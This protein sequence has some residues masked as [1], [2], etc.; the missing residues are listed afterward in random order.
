[1]ISSEAGGGLS[2]FL[3][4]IIERQSA[5]VKILCDALER[6]VD[7]VIL[8]D[9]LGRPSFLNNTAKRVVEQNDG[10]SIAGG[11]LVARRAS[12]RR[13]LG[14][15]I[16]E[17]L[18]GK[19]RPSAG[20]ANRVLI[21]RPS[22]AKPYILFLM[23]TRADQRIPDPAR[24]ACIVHIHILAQPRLPSEDALREAFGLTR[25]E[26]QL[27]VELVRSPHLGAAASKSGM[28]AN[29]ARNHLRAIFSKTGANN[30]AEA[31]QLLARVP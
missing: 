24:Y 17:I 14:Q 4:E 28:A 30:Q 25:R 23:A 16:E 18:V 2:T 6:H 31:I 3:L 8:L 27:V 26:A 9:G 22:G 19:A 15:A 21:S 7:G 29:T 11:T 1:M 5:L 12:E 20:K 13:K 10:L